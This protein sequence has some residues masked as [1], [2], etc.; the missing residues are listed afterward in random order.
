M[1]GDTRTK[2]RH[3]LV[4]PNVATG[5]WTPEQVWETGFVDDYSDNLAYLA[6]EQ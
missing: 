3:I 1:E 2:N 5:D 4:G 6:V